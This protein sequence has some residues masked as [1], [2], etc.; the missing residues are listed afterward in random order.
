MFDPESVWRSMAFHNK[1]GV[2][3]AFVVTVWTPQLMAHAAA[4][5]VALREANGEPISLSGALRTVFGKLPA[6]ILLAFLIGVP[7]VF[8]SFLFVIP[9]IFATA[10]G[11]MIVPEM[12]IRNLSVGPALRAGFRLGKQYIFTMTLPVV[13][14]AA[15]GIVVFLA[16]SLISVFAPGIVA[17][18]AYPIAGGLA[19][20][21]LG[22]IASC[23]CIEHHRAGGAFTLRTQA[24][25]SLG[26]EA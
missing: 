26:G 20:S 24:A 3:L 7:A 21:W 14:A 10:I 19:S 13:A 4:A 15:F 5:W 9:G 16:V 11:V 12:I 2:L 18:A 1:L 6:L 22:A 23:V 17:L 25:G 8:G